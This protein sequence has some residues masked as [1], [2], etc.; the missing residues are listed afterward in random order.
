[1]STT[2]QPDSPSFEFS[3]NRLRRLCRRVM[4]S[5]PAIHLSGDPL[6][7]HDVHTSWLSPERRVAEH[8][9]SFYEGHIVLDGRATLATPDSRQ[10]SAGTILL[11]APH[12]PHAWQTGAEHVLSFVLW[13]DL[14]PHEPIVPVR[15]ATSSH[16]LWVVRWLLAEVQEGA[17]GWNDRV[18][19]F[20]SVL[21]SR[22]LTLTRGAAGPTPD[23]DPD[24][25]LAAVVHRFLWDNLQRPLT[26]AEVA[27]H[28]GM[29]ERNFYRKFQ[30]LTGQTLMQHLQGLR[31]QRA[32]TLLEE[33]DASLAEIGQHV[34]IPDP[35]YFCRC[36][37][38]HTGTSPHKYRL[39]MRME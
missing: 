9:H 8:S 5:V 15:W 16:L 2:I 10:V 27:A 24:G 38:R 39:Y 28:V 34:G 36:F 33:S 21:L 23:A 6:V 26:V 7:L 25:Q 37:K 4:L 11:L 18:T 29:S 35:A 1:M 32:Q 13:F 30:S 22:V 12:T 3:P 17:P 19:A 31:I 14:E 20:L